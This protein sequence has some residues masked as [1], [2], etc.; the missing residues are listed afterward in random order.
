MLVTCLFFSACPSPAPTPTMTDWM[1]ELDASGTTVT[2]TAGGV[3]E[4]AVVSL[5]MI[6]SDDPA[7]ICGPDKTTVCGVWQEAHDAFAATSAL[8]VYT[9]TLDVVTDPT[10]QVANDSTLFDTELSQL[11]VMWTV[12]NPAGGIACFAGGADPAYYITPYGCAQL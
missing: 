11:T 6:Q 5:E 7:F 2:W 12:E 3:D 10:L 9:L 4:D 1:Y 8:T